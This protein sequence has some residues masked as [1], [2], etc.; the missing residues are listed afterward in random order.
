MKV[1]GFTHCT[2]LFVNALDM[3][4]NQS[5]CGICWCKKPQLCTDEL[6]STANKKFYLCSCM[7]NKLLLPIIIIVCTLVKVATSIIMYIPLLFM[8]SHMNKTTSYS[9]GVIRIATGSNA[10]YL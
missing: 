8:W 4:I 3:N 9:Y 1:L 2:C 6:A 10:G 7:R 5:S